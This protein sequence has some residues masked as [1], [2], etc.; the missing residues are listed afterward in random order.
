M[1]LYKNGK[2]IAGVGKSAY[3]YALSGGYSGS[4]S[5]FASFMG[6]AEYMQYYCMNQIFKIEN[7]VLTKNMFTN[8]TYKLV[9]KDVTSKSVL[10]VYYSSDSASIATELGIYEESVDG[11]IQFTITEE[12]PSFNITIDMIVVMNI[13]YDP[14][15]GGVFHIDDAT[16]ANNTSTTSTGYAADARQLNQSVAG[17]FAANVMALIG[18]LQ[19]ENAELKERLDLLTATS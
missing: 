4:E 16:I 15:V 1:G 8:N 5:D 6:N 7:I 13:N 2:K 9:N 12:T 18:Q 17:S 3:A 19:T 11:G 14:S 10:T